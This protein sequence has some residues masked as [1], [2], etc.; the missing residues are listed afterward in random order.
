METALAPS[1]ANAAPAV[2]AAGGIVWGPKPGS[3][4][5]AVV[6]RKRHGGDWTLPKGKWQKGESLTQTATRE[7]QEEI[8]TPALLG[9]FAGT[10][11]YLLDGSVPKVVLF[12][13]ME[14]ASEA[15]FVPSDEVDQLVW[16]RPSAALRRLS[17][18]PEREL[19]SRARGFV[20]S[21]GPKG[22]RRRRLGAEL[23]AYSCELERRIDAIVDGAGS[24]ASAAEVL[25]G[26]SADALRRGNLQEG[27]ECL[28]AAQRMEIFDMKGAELSARAKTLRKEA[29]KLTS[30]RQSA[31]QATLDLLPPDL[32][33]QEEP[34]DKQHWLVFRATRLRDE[35]FAN[36]YFR[37]E[38]SWQQ[39]KIVGLILLIVTASAVALLTMTEALTPAGQLSHQVLLIAVVLFGA[40]GAGFSTALSLLQMPLQAR[41]P[42][43]MAQWSVTLTRPLLGAVAGLVTYA[44]LQSGLFQLPENLFVALLAAFAAGF[45]DRLVLRAVEAV[46]GAGVR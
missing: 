28:L 15:R 25:L 3:R 27:W 1:G 12:W 33:D 45:S 5:I 16:L 20:H 32:V 41:I 26:R 19:V 35:H 7:V 21:V 31:V 13:H 43:R 2:L 17:Y 36:L 23:A 40:M 6:H 39:L 4:R 37:Q 18:E 46:G 44:F 34:K 10:V 42:E 38:L 14:L 29:G 8:G 11:D 24:W 30:W 9:A 22:I